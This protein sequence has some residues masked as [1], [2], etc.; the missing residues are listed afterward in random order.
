M[1]MLLDVVLDVLGRVAVSD[2]LVVG[3]EHVGLGAHVLQLNTA[4][5][6]AEVVSTGADGRWGGRR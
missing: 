4:L 6:G 3:D 1:T 2:D 5:E